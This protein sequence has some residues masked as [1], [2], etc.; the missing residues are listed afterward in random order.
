MQGNTILKAL[1]VASAGFLGACSD[2]DGATSPTTRTPQRT[3]AEVV[4]TE[5]PK[6]EILGRAPLGPFFLNQ[7]PEM[8]FRSNG[9]TDFIIQRLVSPPSPGGWHTHSGPTFSF[10]ERGTVVITR[11]SKKHGCVATTY[12]AGDTYFEEAGEVHVASV[13]EPATAVEY[14]VRFYLPGDGS[15]S[16]SVPAPACAGE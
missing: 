11:Y 14:K 4:P 13:P 15:L 8:M 16:T 3:S 7:M 10:V 6:T 1:A 9:T 2:S 5:P 12:T